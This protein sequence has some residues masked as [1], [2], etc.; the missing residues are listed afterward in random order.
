MM[1]RMFAAGEQPAACQNIRS[2]NGPR[3]ATFSATGA[4]HVKTR[5]KNRL[6]PDD[7]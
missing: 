2:T 1:G 6:V 5:I 7:A 3:R 4:H